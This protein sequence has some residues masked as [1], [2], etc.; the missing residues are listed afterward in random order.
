MQY[1]EETTQKVLIVLLVYVQ[2]I[3]QATHDLRI[4]QLELKY[5]EVYAQH[6]TWVTSTQQ[7]ADTCYVE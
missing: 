5:F 3:V 2:E 7:S 1:P 6:G 4:L